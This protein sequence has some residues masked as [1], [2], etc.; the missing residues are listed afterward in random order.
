[1]YLEDA[2]L[3]QFLYMHNKRYILPWNC[4]TPFSWCQLRFR[5]KTRVPMDLDKSG[6]FSKKFGRVWAYAA[7]KKEE[8]DEPDMCGL[9]RL[10]DWTCTS[11]RYTCLSL[12]QFHGISL[13][14]IRMSLK[15]LNLPSQE[16]NL[17]ILHQKLRCF[18]S[19]AKT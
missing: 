5:W 19:L 10:A 1:M 18:F 3:Y 11:H 2:K 15:S 12:V 16:S 4:L 9:N 8:K 7:F 14:I 13:Y 6:Y 17:D